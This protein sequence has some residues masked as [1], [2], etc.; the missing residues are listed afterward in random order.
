MDNLC[1]WFSG[2][3]SV[4]LLTFVTGGFDSFV[5]WMFPALILR[6]A[7]SIP[8]A[9]PEIALNL[10][11]VFCYVLAGFSMSQRRRMNCNFSI[12]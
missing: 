9:A 3:A 8:H 7:L 5:F 10:V 11:I 12:R 2:W 6:N 4:R 1:H